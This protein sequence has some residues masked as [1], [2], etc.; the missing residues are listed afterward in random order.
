MEQNKNENKEPQM[1][2][3]VILF[4]EVIELS[5]S[6]EVNKKKIKNN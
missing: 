6:K 4:K 2:E 1:P 5:K 3:W